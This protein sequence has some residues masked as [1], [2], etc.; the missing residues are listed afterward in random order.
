MQAGEDQFKRM[1]SGIAKKA[2]ASLTAPPEGSAAAATGAGAPGSGAAA[3]ASS[4]PPGSA[5]ANALGVRQQKQAAVGNAA[6]AAA[7]AAA[8]GVH[9]RVLFTDKFL[10]LVG[11]NAG[12]KKARAKGCS[13]ACSLN[14]YDQPFWALSA[15][16][17]P[18]M[19]ATC[20]L[21]RLCANQTGMPPF[22]HGTAK[23]PFS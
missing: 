21:T 22:K 17:Q 7:N 14:Q 11:N 1:S 6:A 12:I 9:P 16:L 8:A 2:A 3:N 10:S 4:D 19:D 18:F 13:A 23:L 20:I 5:G 15:S